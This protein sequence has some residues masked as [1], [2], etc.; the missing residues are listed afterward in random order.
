MKIPVQC[1][2]PATK[3]NS[4]LGKEREEKGEEIIQNHAVP[5]FLNA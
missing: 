2:I 4:L 3:A 1:S 5:E